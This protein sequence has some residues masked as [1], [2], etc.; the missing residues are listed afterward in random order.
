M[1]NR[2]FNLSCP[3]HVSH[4]NW[5]F[6]TL[7]QNGIVPYRLATRLEGKDWKKALDTQ[8]FNYWAT[9]HAMTDVSPAKLMSGRDIR[10][11]LPEFGESERSKVLDG[12]R[13]IEYDFYIDHFPHFSKNSYTNKS[14]ISFRAYLAYF[15][16]I[17]KNIGF[18]RLA[19]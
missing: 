8:L 12:G 4:D 5:F 17:I 7:Q 14:N 13:K 9:P 18:Q 2:V 10:T 6:S 16:D 11:K 15:L 19:S 1:S 3:G